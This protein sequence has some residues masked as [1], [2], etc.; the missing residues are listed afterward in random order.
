MVHILEDAYPA[1]CAQADNVMKHPVD[2][3]EANQAGFNEAFAT[4][5]AFFE[6]LQEDGQAARKENFAKA[7]GGL[8]KPG[9]MLD[10]AVLVD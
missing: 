6:W 9:G 3:G 5:K 4:D 8:S 10:G 2:E 7:M 1:T